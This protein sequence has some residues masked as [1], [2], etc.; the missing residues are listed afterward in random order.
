VFVY[1]I[2]GA[3]QIQRG[4][5]QPGGNRLG[6]SRV[7]RTV[8][9]LGITS[10]LTDI[11][12]EM[13]NTVLPLYLF[14]MLG[15]APLQFGI[16]DGLYQGGAVLVRVASGLVSDRTRTPKRVAAAGYALSAFTKVGLL[17]ASGATAVTSLIVVDRIGKGIRTAPRDALIALSTKPA[18]LGVA[19]G[20]HR[21]LDTLG[22]MIGPLVA[23][24]VLTLLPNA[25]DVVFVISVCI[26]ILGVGVLVIF[27]RDQ[28]D[29]EPAGA[30]P[31]ARLSL[32]DM[33]AV[34]VEPRFR[35]LVLVGAAL[36]ALT[37]SD[38]FIYLVLQRRLNIPVGM[39][40]LLYVAT[41]LA[42]MVL[43]V[44]FGRL[45]DRFGRQRVF[46]A[47]Y[48][49]LV[50]VYGSLLLPSFGLAH[51]VVSLGLLGAYYAMTD[52]VLAAL[53][54]ALLP[55]E[56]RATGLGALSAATG[57]ARLLASVVFGLAWTF[58]DVTTAVTLFTAGLLLGVVIA[59]VVLA[60]TRMPA[61]IVGGA[62]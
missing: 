33:A 28:R 25:F 29:E 13:V 49:V 24:A 60:R 7:S 30:E 40:P 23:F 2:E 32:R 12:A 21:A 56:A 43:A 9:L 35:A 5:A 1:Q 59:A 44:P 41:A 52:G 39:F 34:L 53:G 19:F 45:A 48:L 62:G 58:L 46:L 4:A 3:R 51:V 36:G 14:F 47:G 42:Y 15:L 50:I 17:V 11:S 27:V 37:I 61:P 31:A 55:T 10:M 54:S 26:A 20:V 38:A 16:I 6:I 57:L 18:D 22:A 8:V